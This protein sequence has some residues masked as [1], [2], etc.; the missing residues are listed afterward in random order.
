[1]GQLIL[2][3]M[4]YLALSYSLT[5]I[6]LHTADWRNFFFLKGKNIGHKIN[7]VVCGII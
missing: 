2:N 4:L 1:M 6:Q 7:R 5:L 3:M